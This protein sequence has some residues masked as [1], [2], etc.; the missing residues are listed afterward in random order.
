LGRP[1]IVTA[2]LSKSCAPPAEPT[3][4]EWV[5]PLMLRFLRMSWGISA[6]ILQSAFIALAWSAPASSDFSLLN[7]V[8]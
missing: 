1:F 2:R 6:N 8:P 4:S 3:A 5:T 7:L